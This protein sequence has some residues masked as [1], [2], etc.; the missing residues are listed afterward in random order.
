MELALDLNDWLTYLHQK[1]SSIITHW[2]AFAIVSLGVIGF[3]VQATT[4][5]K[6]TSFSPGAL[7]ILT[8]SY[9]GFAY[10]NGRGLYRT[11]SQYN[12][13]HDYII[14]LLEGSS[15][16]DALAVMNGLLHNPA[17]HTFNVTAT[18][19]AAAVFVGAVIWHRQLANHFS[20]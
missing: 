3:V 4:S 14:S 19:A 13:T 16:S 9:L 12:D 18:Y 11:Q 17:V 5:S 20:R 1:E 7:W 6:S 10:V 2:N 8:V 15:R